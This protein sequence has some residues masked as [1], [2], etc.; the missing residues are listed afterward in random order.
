MKGGHDARI[1]RLEGRIRPRVGP[2]GI[3]MRRPPD[4]L[5]VA[6]LDELEHY[7]PLEEQSYTPEVVRTCVGRALLGADLSAEEV[8]DLAPAY[9]QMFNSYFE[10]TEGGGGEPY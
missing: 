2:R 7:V 8:R 1:G 5:Q 9:E 6:I 4:P 10:E 3:D